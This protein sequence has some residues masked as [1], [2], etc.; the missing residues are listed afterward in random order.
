MLDFEYNPR[1]EDSRR[2]MSLDG[3][4]Y[5]THHDKLLARALQS[6]PHFVSCTQC[7]GG[8][9]VSQECLQSREIER[10][11][12]LADHRTVNRSYILTS[13]YIYI[14][15]YIDSSH[16][17]LKSFSLKGVLGGKQSVTQSSSEI[18][19]TLAVSFSG[20]S[21]PLGRCTTLASAFLLP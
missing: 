12:E 15:I 16:S 13:I 8:G 14:Y 20:C 17:R 7:K 4:L 5:Q 10:A 18:V 6:D 21:H 11:Q 19:L 3:R 1:P 9:F 2:I